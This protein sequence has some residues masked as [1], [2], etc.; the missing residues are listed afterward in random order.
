MKVI[1]LGGFLKEVLGGAWSPNGQ[2][3]ALNGKGNAILIL[4]PDTQ[5]VAMISVGQEESIQVIAWR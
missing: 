2:Y 5:T 4:E 3:V 1:Y